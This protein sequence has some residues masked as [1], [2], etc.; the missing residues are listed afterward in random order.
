M[1]AAF[2]KDSIESIHNNT[3]PLN[4]NKALKV[5]PSIAGINAVYSRS[6]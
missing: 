3:N 2:M 5:R 1:P 6:F 4:D